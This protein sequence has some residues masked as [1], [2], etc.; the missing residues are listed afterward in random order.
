MKTIKLI[1][2][3]LFCAG[4]FQA[5]VMY[6][7]QSGGSHQTRQISGFHGVSVSSGSDIFLKGRANM[8]QANAS[9]GSD[10]NASELDSKKCTASVSSGSDIKV[11]VS[12]E[13]DANASSGGDITYSG[14]PK[15]KDI[16]KLTSF[17]S[18][19]KKLL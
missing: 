15:T 5:T 19:K 7:S 4:L 6:A 2:L 1:T 12:D 10:I 14:N 3:I 16:K 11:S 9:S 13:L 8:V 18:Q 17:L